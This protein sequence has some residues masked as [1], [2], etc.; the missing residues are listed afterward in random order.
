MKVKNASFIRYLPDQATQQFILRQSKL[1]G[2]HAWHQRQTDK[3]D[4]VCL[5]VFRM[6]HETI[7]ALLQ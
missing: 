3:Q 2:I 1:S 5:P 4:V 6:K 7:P